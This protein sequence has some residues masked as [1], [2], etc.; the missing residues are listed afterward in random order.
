MVQGNVHDET[1]GFIGADRSMFS[2]SW[3][4]VIA[5]LPAQMRIDTDPAYVVAAYREHFPQMSPSDVYFAAS[6]A[7]RSWRGQVIEAEERAKA[8]APAY[9]YQ[10]NFQSPREGGIYGA[11]HT[12]DI[13]LAFG[14]LDAE[15]SFTGVGA[16]AEAASHQLQQAFIALAKTGNPNCEAIPPWSPYTLEKRETMIVDT[17]CRMEDNPRQWERELFAKIPYIQPGT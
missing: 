2:Y 6:T 9:V 13:A 16:N 3:D 4:E 5:H 17:Q 14:N 11:P 10:V 7:A 8:G 15:G 1:R 12:I